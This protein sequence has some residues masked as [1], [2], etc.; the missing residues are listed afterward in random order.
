[1]KDTTALTLEGFKREAKNLRKNNP[2]IKSHAKALDLLSNE[3]GHK[4]WKTLKPVIEKQEIEKEKREAESESKKITKLVESGV[5]NLIEVMCDVKELKDEMEFDYP[6]PLFVLEE[7]DR[8][9]SGEKG[10]PFNTKENSGTV[11]SSPKFLGREHFA[12]VVMFTREYEDLIRSNIDCVEVGYLIEKDDKKI[13][14][15]LNDMIE[16]KITI[17]LPE[18]DYSVSFSLIN[19]YKLEEIEDDPLRWYAKIQFSEVHSMLTILAEGLISA[20]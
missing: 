19:H 4:S 16:T 6:Y 1:M 2:E 13:L 20:R 12:Y 18:E 11:Y 7:E 3:Y 15:I 5:F 17:E 10:L 14:Q 9:T 8:Q